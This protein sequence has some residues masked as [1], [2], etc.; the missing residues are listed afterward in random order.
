MVE[1]G[2]R[3]DKPEDCPQ[4]VFDVMM[5]CWSADTDKRP[6]FKT[7]EKLF[8]DLLSSAEKRQCVLDN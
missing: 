8:S 7:L 3:L 1:N 4:D 2:G 5:E 6:S